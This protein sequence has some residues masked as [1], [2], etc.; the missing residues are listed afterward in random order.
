MEVQVTSEIYIIRKLCPNPKH[1]K[2]SLD[3]TSTCNMNA[4]PLNSPLDKMAAISQMAFW[5]IF[6]KEE[7]WMNVVPK[8]LIDGNQALV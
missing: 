6:L 1:N 7:V 8:G 4:K 3:P 5:N 2:L